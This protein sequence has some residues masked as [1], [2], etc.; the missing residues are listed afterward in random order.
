[1]RHNSDQQLRHAL[2]FSVPEAPLP[3]IHKR[4][5]FA[6]LRERRAR[7]TFGAIMAA[8]LM[9]T[10]AGMKTQTPRTTAPVPFADRAIPSPLASAT[11]LQMLEH[12]QMD[13]HVLVPAPTP[14]PAPMVT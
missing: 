7:Y 4:A 14:A 13:T 10:M 1:M 9:V 2:N 3:A 12:E 8:V 6:A 11:P 5:E